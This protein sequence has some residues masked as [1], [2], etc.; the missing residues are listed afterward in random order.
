M[1]VFVCVCVCVCVRVFACCTHGVQIFAVWFR[2]VSRF[3]CAVASRSLA[4]RADRTGQA[5]SVSKLILCTCAAGRACMPP[6]HWRSLHSP[7]RTH[8]RPA[9]HF[10]NRACR[11][12]L[13]TPRTSC[14]PQCPCTQAS[15]RGS[16]CGCGC[17]CGCG[18][19]ERPAAR[20][21]TT[22]TNTSA[23]LWDACCCVPQRGS[24]S[25]EKDAFLRRRAIVERIHCHVQTSIV[26][27][28]QE[29]GNCVPSVDVNVQLARGGGVVGIGVGGGSRR[30]GEERFL[31][32]VCAQ[33]LCVLMCV[34]VYVGNRV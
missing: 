12:L 11:S 14:C 6:R 34:C 28:W 1:C 32:C 30:S 24:L 2:R 15:H 10:P 19:D 25:A 18:P 29:A 8:N 3:A 22:A 5:G 16:G 31:M 21:A 17:R 33:F 23:S 20:G 9:H 26:I 13:D 27:A 7:Q 4:V